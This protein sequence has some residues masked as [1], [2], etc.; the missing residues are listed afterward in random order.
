MSNNHHL[1]RW[2][3]AG[4]WIATVGIG[5]VV[6]LAYGLFRPAHA[7]N[8]EPKSPAKPAVGAS[9]KADG[10][11]LTKEEIAAKVASDIGSSEPEQ[12]ATV[13]VKEADTA[14][15]LRDIKW[16]SPHMWA[17]YAIWF[18]SIIAVSFAVERFWACG[19]ARSCRPIWPPACG[20]WPAARAR[21]ISAMPSGF[22]SN[23]RPRWRRS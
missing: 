13:P 15:I 17:F 16:L 3:V 5:I 19:G 6:A 8:R 2:T 7:Q 4:R 23:I 1:L 20:P 12:K 22:A 14:S 11:P 18:V 10:G 21:S 9:A